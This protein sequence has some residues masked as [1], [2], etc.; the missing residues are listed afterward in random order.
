MKLVGCSLLLLQPA[1]LTRNLKGRLKMQLNNYSLSVGKKEL[2]TNVTIDFEKGSICNLLGG[3]GVGKSS[4]AKSLMGMLKYKGEVI[5]DG[6]LCVIGSYTNV[7]YDLT[8]DDL[9]KIIKRKYSSDLL[10]ELYELLQIDGISQNLKIG[11]MSDGQKQKVKLLFFLSSNPD[12]IVLDEFTSSLDKKSMLDAYSFFKHYC[13]KRNV[14][15]INIT[16]NIL[17]LENLGGKYYYVTQKNIILYKDK[18][19]LLEAYVNL[20]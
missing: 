8:I 7:P 9:L 11:K 18:E 17:D 20:N 3:N 6:T 14:L 19:K 16:H 12:V 1:F 10:D 4:F 13:R 15:I 5:Y 2:F